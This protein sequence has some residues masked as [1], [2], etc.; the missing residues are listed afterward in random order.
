MRG[1]E[2]KYRVPGPL[3][4]ALFDKESKFMAP[5]LQS[6]A[7]FSRLVVKEANGAWVTDLDGN[8]YLD[9]TAGI[10]VGSIGHAHPHYVNQ[11]TR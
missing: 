1:Q 4:E 5:G 7:L 2:K 10:G 6:I 11:S 9:F 8:K 3:S